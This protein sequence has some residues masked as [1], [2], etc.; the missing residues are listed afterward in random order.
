M[1]EPAPRIRFQSDEWELV[2]RAAEVADFDDPKEFVRE[3]ALRFVDET[4]DED[5][6]LKCPHEDCDRTFATIRQRRGHLGNVHT[7]VFPE[8]DYWC[9]YCGYGPSKFQGINAHH[10]QRHSN[11]GDPVRLDHD[12][13]P[14]ELLAPDDIPDHQDPMLL[15]RLYH[16]H[17]GCIT[18]MCRA[19]D[20]DVT[21]GRV[22]HY[23]IEF[24]IHEPTPHG[25][26]EDGDGPLYRDREWLKERYEAA[27][28][29]IS[30][31][32]R[33]LEIDVPY[34]TLVKN[35]KRFDFHDPTDP[36]G[37]HHGKGGPKPSA[38]AEPEPKPDDQED[39][40][41][42]DD[43]TKQVKGLDHTDPE[44]LQKALDEHDTLRAAA[45]AFPQV[46]YATVRQ[47]M[48]DDGIYEPDSYDTGSNDTPTT[49]P[50]PNPDATKDPEPDS[51]PAPASVDQTRDSLGVDDPV[52]VDSFHDLDT[53]DWLDE[54]S[55]YQAVDIADDVEELADVLGWAE[56]GLLRRMVELLGIGEDL[57]D[58]QPKRGQEVVA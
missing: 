41:E 16:E 55:F 30:E 13:E 43:G 8:G 39:D 11:Q 24:D 25:D 28:G 35:I 46:T 48:I 29:N 51:E 40:E 34:R 2:E 50:E 38:E 36:P 47:R 54:A 26:T 42:Q 19:H 58:Y 49:D 10:S 45:E 12:P 57:D 31:M 53:P 15:E 27:G 44:D 22:R 5:G 37:K 20:F 14:E 21:V 9:G 4:I 33:N 7:D 3:G 23:L 17:D 32:H 1:A 56:Y 6:Q 18:D 52:A